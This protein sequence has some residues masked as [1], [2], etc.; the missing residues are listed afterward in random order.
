MSMPDW[1]QQYKEK[2]TIPK[3]AGLR[4]RKKSLRCKKFSAK[5]SW[6]SC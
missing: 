3:S 1:I 2:G 5:K 4:L 6:M